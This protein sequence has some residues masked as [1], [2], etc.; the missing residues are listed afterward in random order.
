MDA[1]MKKNIWNDSAV[2]PLSPEQKLTFLWMVSQ[3]N[4]AGIVID[5]ARTFAFHT[6]LAE[7]WF[8]KTIEAM[9]DSVAQDGGEVLLINYIRHQ[10]G[11]GESLKGNRIFKCVHKAYA[12]IKSPTLRGLIETACPEIRDGAPSYTKAD[13][14]TPEEVNKAAEIY[15]AYPRKAGRPKA[16][17]AILKALVGLRGTMTPDQLLAATQAFAKS[18]IGEDQQYTPHPTTWFNQERWADTVVAAK[19]APRITPQQAD[20][21]FQQIAKL[22]DDLRYDSNSNAKA[23]TEALIDQHQDLLKRYANQS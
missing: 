10:I 8:S 6:G 1:K 13:Q 15:E 5:T 23:T 17:T 4:H 22:R 18:R 7:E 3:A 16:L 11:E 19:K 12:A 20:Y 2:Q 21:A 14:A 9:Q